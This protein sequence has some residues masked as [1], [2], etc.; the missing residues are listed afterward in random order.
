MEDGKEQSSYTHMNL[1]KA[2]RSLRKN[3]QHLFVFEEWTELDI[4]NT[5]N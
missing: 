3:I 5:T 4:P 2:Y 1:R